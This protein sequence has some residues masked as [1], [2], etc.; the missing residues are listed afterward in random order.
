MIRT[1]QFMLDG[2]T[3]TMFF[4]DLQEKRKGTPFG[5]GKTFSK[6]NIFCC[7]HENQPIRNILSNKGPQPE[8][9]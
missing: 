3:G 6:K 8:Y 5:I 2:R 9:G 4:C 1:K 7:W